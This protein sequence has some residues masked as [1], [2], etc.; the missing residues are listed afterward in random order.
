MSG[1]L[2]TAS[3]QKSLSPESM[4]ILNAHGQGVLQGGFRAIL[5]TSYPP[6]EYLDSEVTVLI[7]DELDS[8]ETLEFL[9]LNETTAS[10]VWQ[11][12]LERQK[13]CPHRANVLDSAKRYIDSIQK[14]AIDED[15]DWVEVMIRIGLSSNFQARIM[16]K[17]MKEMRLSG[18]L[19][20]W[21]IEMMEMRYDFLEALDGKINV[22]EHHPP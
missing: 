4:Q 17:D 1:T 13:E 21:T 10:I 6:A 14:N 16:G 18:S 20:E 2:T 11:R 12:F 7:P 19:K 9:E 15:D 8:Q 22:S 3:S 5:S